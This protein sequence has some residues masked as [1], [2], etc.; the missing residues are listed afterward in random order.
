MPFKVK[1]YKK[2]ANRKQKEVNAMTEKSKKNTWAQSVKDAME[3]NVKAHGPG[4]IIGA[5]RNDG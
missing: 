1:N 2:K 3:A 4:V 5:I